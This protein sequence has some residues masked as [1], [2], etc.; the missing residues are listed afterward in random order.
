ML[1]FLKTISIYNTLLLHGP[2]ILEKGLI[3]SYFCSKFMSFM[4]QHITSLMIK[5]VRAG[6][7][8]I[9]LDTCADLGEGVVGGPPHLS[10]ENWNLLNSQI[11]I[12]K[13][14]P[15]LLDWKTKV[16]L[17]PQRRN[18]SWSVHGF[19]IRGA[20]IIK[21][22]RLRFHKQLALAWFYVKIS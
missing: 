11:S 18:F 2:F 6:F 5:P 8:N 21:T 7:R 1:I 10:L 17:E 16:S 15:P 3:K 19:W 9:L 20:L 22:F 12:T 14:S 4:Q 13:N